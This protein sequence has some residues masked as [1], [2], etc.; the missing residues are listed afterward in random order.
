[1]LNPQNGSMA[2]GSRRTTPTAPDCAAVVSDATEAPTNTPCGQSNACR[3]SGAV[4]ARRPPNRMAEIGT[5]CG[6]SQ[7]DEID[8]HCDAGAVKREFGCAA[9]SL[10]PFCQSLPRQSMRCAGTSP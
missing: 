2:I 6:S 4:R 10:D 5:P 3:T 7:C 8:G 9:F 1:M